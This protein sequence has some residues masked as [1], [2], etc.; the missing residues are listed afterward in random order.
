MEQLDIKDK[1]IIYELDRDSRQTLNEIARKV[2]LS[3]DVINYRIK[4]LE[5]EGYILG[6]QT[7]IDFTKIGYI[8]V[9]FHIS[10]INTSPKKENEII[11]YLT[12]N[13]KIFLVSETEGYTNISVGI[14]VKEIYEIKEFQK[15][16]EQRFKSNIKEAKLGIYM[17]LYHFNR[18]YLIGKTTST[19]KILAIN[20]D[21]KIK[22]NEKDIEI[23]KLLSKNS[24]IPIIEIASKLKMNA[25]TVAARINSLEKNKIILGYKIIFGFNKINYNYIKVDLILNDISRE[26]EIL[27]FCENHNNIIYALWAVGGADIELFFEIESTERFLEVM[28]EIREK[29]KEIIEWKYSILTKYHKFNYF[30]D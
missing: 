21:K 30:L 25:N 28:K 8:A 24:R 29:F 10:L 14:L 6:Y 26:K 4:K 9:R 22:T 5:K 11:T 7:L 3:K 20:S 12:K 2:K 1:K 16:F 19:D 23:L 27:Q 15:K 18:D 17:D 13:P